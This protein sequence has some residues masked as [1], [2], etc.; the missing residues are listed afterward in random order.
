VLLIREADAAAGWRFRAVRFGNRAKAI[1]FG[2]W[3]QTFHFRTRQEWEVLFARHGL[4]A[5]AQAADE[6]TPF[7]N[8]LFRLTATPPA[9]ASTS[10][11]ALPA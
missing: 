7:A 10:P 4:Q 5:A 3:R 6:G 9:S 1:A 2:A 8:V 11:A